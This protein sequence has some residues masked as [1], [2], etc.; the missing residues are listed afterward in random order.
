[1]LSEDR[2]HRILQE[3]AVKGSLN[4]AEL[5]AELGVSGMT[6]RRDLA[7]LAGR[8]LLN[9][10]H[11]GAVPVNNPPS[12]LSGPGRNTGATSDNDR[13]TTIGMI[14][15]SASYYFPGIIRGAE[16]AAREAGVRLVLGVSNYSMEEERRQLRRLYDLGVDGV[17]IT[18]SEPSVAGTETLTLLNAAVVPVVVVER[19][20]DDTLEDAP[21][22][23]VRSDHARGAQIAIR[24][25]LNLGHRRISLFLREESPTAWQLID[26]YHAAIQRAGLSEDPALVRT[27]P[28]AHKDPQAHR[29]WVGGMLEWCASTG[30]T[31]ALIHSDEDALQFASVCQEQGMDI[32]GDLAI[33]AYDDEIASLCNV[34]LTAV[35]PPKFDVGYQALM[36][37]LN[38]IA[39]SRRSSRA[40]Q[41]VVLS[42]SLVVRSS[43]VPENAAREALGA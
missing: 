30:V 28:R 34:P 3:L 10:V 4:A 15:P 41:R 23:S 14:V 6:L 32:P 5:A 7:L 38:R 9:R 29:S 40:L 33:V 25:L 43:T 27:V 2:K 36:T 19:S 31:A 13:R 22:E 24:H 35:S 39:A 8:G 17:L 20:I 26:G 18:P 42:P 12:A 1:M 21:I 11:G 16:A 37:C